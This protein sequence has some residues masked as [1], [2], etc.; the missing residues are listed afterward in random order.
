MPPKLMSP[1][2]H[3]S[4]VGKEAINKITSNSPGDE[5]RGGS[6]SSR[7]VLGGVCAPVSYKRVQRELVCVE[8][9][10]G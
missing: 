3:S 6:R 1:G 9:W 4:E 2:T 7:A 8:T 5:C 10:R